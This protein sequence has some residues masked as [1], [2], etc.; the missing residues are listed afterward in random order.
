MLLIRASDS[1]SIFGAFTASPWKESKE[2]Y[3]TDD[4]FLYQVFPEVTVCRP[5]G[6]SQN[7]MFCRSS[8]QIGGS[9][10]GVGQT[11]GMG[12]GS[13]APQGIGFGGSSNR[14]PRLFFDQSFCG[15]FVSSQDTT[16]EKGYLL[17]RADAYSRKTF[18][19][20]EQIEVWGCG[21]DDIVAAALCAREQDRSVRESYLNQARMVDK[22]AFVSDFRTGLI[23]SKAFG[24]MDDIRDST[25]NI[26]LDRTPGGQGYC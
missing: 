13:Q 25:R 15:C 12:G 22:A 3:G 6:R 21:G 17:P 19:N 24:H 2:Y 1:G 9:R 16:F 23:E 8:S 20:A 4:C 14:S 5:S 18:F 7:Y 26:L 11:G 10:G